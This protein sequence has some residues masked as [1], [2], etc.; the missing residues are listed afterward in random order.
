MVCYNMYK[1]VVELGERREEKLVLLHKSF[2]VARL[3]PLARAFRKAFNTRDTFSPERFGG[4]PV[5]VGAL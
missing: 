5:C 2:L 1:K 3:A 4:R